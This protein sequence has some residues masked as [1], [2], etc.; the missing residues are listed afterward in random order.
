MPTNVYDVTSPPDTQL[1]NLL[2]LDLRNL[3]LNIQQR[4]ALISGTAAAIWNPALD[5]QPAN[6]TGLL[7]FA[8]DTGQIFQ[9]SG[10]AWVQISLGN[11]KYRDTTVHNLAVAGAGIQTGSTIT[12]PLN[13][14]QVGSVVSVSARFTNT[15]LSG[16]PP[17]YILS[18]GTQNLLNVAINSN[19]TGHFR[20]DFVVSSGSAESGVFEL[21]NTQ[22]GDFLA[23][24]N[25]T[26]NIVTTSLTIATKVQGF[27]TSSST[28]FFDYLSVTVN[29]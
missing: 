21:F 28:S 12:I 13:T 14:L 26:V 17:A 20:G 4:M 5:A 3:A 9:W 10:A 27:S 19:A 15:F 29:T 22:T 8:T 25:D 2:G 18:V 16:V 11:V 6:W 24:Y 1:A 23:L 7:Y